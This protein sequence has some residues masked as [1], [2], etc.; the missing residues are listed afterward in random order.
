MSIEVRL[1]AY[2]LLADELRTQITTGRLRPGDRLP[3]EPQLCASSGVSRSTVREALRLLASQNLIVTTR[4]VAGGSFVVHPSP[5][6]ISETLAT[7][8]GLLL[9]NSVLTIEALLEVRATLEVPLAGL[10]AQR[11]T[12][13][14]LALLAAGLFDPR[15]D[16]PD[17]MLDRHRAFHLALALAS[18]NRLFE[19]VSRPLYTVAN[20]REIIGEKGRDFWLRV[21][22][23]HRV[24]L[25]AV[26][27]GD[28]A[29]AQTVA[30]GHLDH[31]TRAIS[32][33][34]A[35]ADA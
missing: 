3:T 26:R 34:T 4:G 11:R 18:G 28:A 13:S 9:A 12:D 7:G 35:P 14:H 23:D 20:E 31:L 29:C 8:V 25:A 30:G 15:T 22:A 10:A 1:P 2:Q 19:L 6:Q 33:V 27:A 17:R 24:L 32:G 21:D 5:D 16:P